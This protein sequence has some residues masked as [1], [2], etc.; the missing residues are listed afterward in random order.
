[1]IQTI[2]QPDS[3]Q[4]FNGSFFNHFVRKLAQN[5]HWQLNVFI[6]CHRG[7]KVESLKNESDLL[8]TQIR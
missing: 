2:L 5:L 7:Q 8:Q 1:M 6:C 4:K 3:S